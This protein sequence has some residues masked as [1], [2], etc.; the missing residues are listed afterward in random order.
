VAAAGSTASATTDVLV[1][2]GGIAGGALAV[3][4]A[5]GGLGVTVLERSEQY[6]DRVRG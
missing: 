3:H 5:R 6:R 4:L 1:V 2:G